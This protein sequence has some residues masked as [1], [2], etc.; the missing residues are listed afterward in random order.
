MVKLSEWINGGEPSLHLVETFED[1]GIG[2][3]GEFVEEK[4][5]YAELVIDFSADMQRGFDFVESLSRERIG[6]MG[7]RL[8]ES[9]SPFA[10]DE[11]DK[12]FLLSLL[13]STGCVKI[14]LQYV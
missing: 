12:T 11:L 7:L 1:M 13:E 3:D 2:V 4:V 5:W 10:V 14:K 9:R 6:A 8:Y